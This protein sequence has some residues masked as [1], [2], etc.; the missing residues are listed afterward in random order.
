MPERRLRGLYRRPQ[1]VAPA[2]G[3]WS[4]LTAELDELGMEAALVER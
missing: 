1:L 4:Q 3:C 2:Q